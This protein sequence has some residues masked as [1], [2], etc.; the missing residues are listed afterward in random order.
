M[1]EAPPIPRLFVLEVS[2]ILTPTLLLWTLMPIL[3]LTLGTIL[4]EVND[5]RSSFEE[6]NGEM[7][8]RWR[9]FTLFPKQLHVPLFLTKTAVSPKFVILLLRQLRAE[10]PQLR[11]LF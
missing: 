7:C 6:L 9:T 11:C 10:I 8:M 1:E 4:M 3:L 5:A 2:Q